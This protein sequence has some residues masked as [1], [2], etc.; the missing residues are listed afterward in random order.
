MRSE[1]K[2]ADIAAELR[3]D[4]IAGLEDRDLGTFETLHGLHLID[5]IPSPRSIFCRKRRTGA[6]T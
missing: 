5:G 3:R 4:F 1:Q 2:K 6:L